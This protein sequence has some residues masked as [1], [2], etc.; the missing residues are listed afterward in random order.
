MTPIPGPFIVLILPLLAAA[1][2]FLVR[3]WALP[4]ALLSATVTG[5]LAVLCLRLPLDRSAF[6]L[7]Q[8]VAFG[9][10]VVIL[11]RNLMLDP[12]GQA[13]LAFGFALAT[14]LFLVAWR[15]SQGHSFFPISL[16]V[17]SLY[18][19]I[20]L[21]HS[22]TLTAIVLAISAALLTFVIR[23]EQS[24]AVQGAQRYLVV[25]LLA[26]PLIVAAIWMVDQSALEPANAALARTALLPAALGFGLLLAAIPFSMWLPALTADAPPLVSAFV[27]TLSQGMAIYLMMAFVNS[28]PAAGGMPAVPATAQLVGLLMAAAGGLMAA[29]QRDWGR[30]LG[31]AAL[32]SMGYFLLAWGTGS[33]HSLTL[34]LLHMLNRAAAITL[35]AAALAILRH[36]AA[37]DDFGRLHGV[38]RRLPVAT[39]GLVLGG[40]ALAGFPFT[41]GFPTYWAVSRAIVSGEWAWVEVIPPWSAGLILLA[42]TVGIVVGVLRGLGAML[43]DEPRPDV[44]SQPRI[45]SALVLALAGLALVVGFY[46]QLFL[47]LAQAMF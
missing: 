47:G 18:A 14:A 41:A 46:P 7:G 37:G 8:E 25:A 19:L 3:R 13:W 16:A 6:V 45:A 43:G 32:S 28:N 12:A 11:G 30:L 4:A 26:V 9:R 36:R 24:G 39:A 17:L 22:L 44:P 34:A 27:L 5:A 40:L 33:S 38:A 31:Y 20:A 29:V 42:G 23:R 1:L 10:P 35:M 15:I 2:V 21:L